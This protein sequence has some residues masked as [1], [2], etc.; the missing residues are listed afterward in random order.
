MMDYA[1]KGLEI[2]ALDHGN[3]SGSALT[4]HHAPGDMF[5]I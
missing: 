5:G 3:A 4:F 2:P 1:I